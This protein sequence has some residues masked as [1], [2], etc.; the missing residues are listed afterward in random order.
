MAWE[1][2]SAMVVATTADRRIPMFQIYD[3][4]RL[5]MEEVHRR[6]ER[7]SRHL[8]PKSRR[9]TRRSTRTLRA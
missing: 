1:E 3:H 7:L 4:A 8:P 5:E 6:A 2:R 9:S